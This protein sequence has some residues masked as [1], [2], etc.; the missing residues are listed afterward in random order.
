[1]IF[2]Y[3]SCYLTVFIYTLTSYKVYRLNIYLFLF[4]CSQ[5]I[6]ILNFIY[7]CSGA[8]CVDINGTGV[9]NL[10]VVDLPGIDKL[11]SQEYKVSLFGFEFSSLFFR[12]LTNISTYFGASTL[13]LKFRFYKINKCILIFHFVFNF[14]FK[15]TFSFNNLNLIILMI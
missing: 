12:T 9:G 15:E 2:F 8:I 6:K 10:K 1:M 4:Q 3:T 11:S 5:I 13:F 14:V 7:F